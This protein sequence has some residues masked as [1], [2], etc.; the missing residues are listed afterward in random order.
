[1]MIKWFQE[2]RLQRWQKKRD[3]EKEAVRKL[4][5]QK[6]VLEGKVELAKKLH[7]KKRDDDN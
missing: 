4:Q 2:R 1:M 7:Q 5:Y 3:A 6:G